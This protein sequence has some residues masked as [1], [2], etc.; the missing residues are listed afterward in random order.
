MEMLSESS[1]TDAVEENITITTTAPTTL[2]PTTLTPTSQPSVAPTSAP[3]AAP[4]TPEPSQSPPPKPTAS[5]SVGPTMAPTISPTEM[6]TVTPT[7][8]KEYLAAK[9]LE[10]KTELAHKA[11]LRLR[12][13]SAES[14]EK[15]NLRHKEQNEKLQV[16]RSIQKEREKKKLAKTIEAVSYTHLT[17]PTIYS[18]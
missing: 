3:S 4:T 14:E 15:S 1:R 5:P 16:E 9:E 10:K 11:M 6:P 13:A 2:T 18:V 12:D 8:S 7:F 17:L